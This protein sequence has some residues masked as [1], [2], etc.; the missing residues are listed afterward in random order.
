MTPNS[1]TQPNEVMPIERKLAGQIGMRTLQLL[2]RSN[3]LNDAAGGD[4]PLIYA[5]PFP[6]R[7]ALIIDPMRVRNINAVLSPR[8]Q[9]HLATALAGRR[10][11]LTN[12][13]GIILQ[14]GYWPEPA[15]EL[16]AKPLDLA[17]Q[18]SPLHVPI[19]ATRRRDLW[20]PIDQLDAVLI[21]SSRR[22]GK[23]TLLHAWIAALLHGGKAQLVLFDG[24]AGMEFGRYR[25]QPRV[26]V[27]DGK[28]GPTL[29]DLFQEMN[30]RIELLRSAGAVSLADYNTLSMGSETQFAVTKNANMNT[31][32]R[33]THCGQR[34]LSQLATCYMKKLK[35]CARMIVATRTT[36]PAK[37]RP[38]GRSK[39]NT[40]LA[41]LKTVSM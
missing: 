33:Q 2:E 5:W 15:R 11:V 26:A 30:R 36:C 17:Q 21:G 29:T 40:V 39:L 34:H 23:S 28:L 32:Q 1:Q 37:L 22:M 12:H 27:V 13:R 4:T 25:G 41:T 6:E 10:V 31:A 19:G 20:L 24:K 16:V 3:M 18:P 8:F 9:H 38:R 7:V 14:V 35:V